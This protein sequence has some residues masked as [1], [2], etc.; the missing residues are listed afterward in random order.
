MTYT[1]CSIIVT[2]I[3]VLPTEEMRET[4]VIFDLLFGN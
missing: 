4:V 1:S 2:V 3:F